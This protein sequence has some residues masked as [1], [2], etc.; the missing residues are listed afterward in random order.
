MHRYLLIFGLTLLLFTPLT[1]VLAQQAT[2]YVPIAK[3]P[4]APA[5]EQI[6]AEK[7]VEY[8]YRLAV[9]VAAMLAVIKIIY[10]GVQWMLTDVVTSKEN[11]KKDI[12]GAI[13]GLIIVL[14]AV[15]ILEVINPKLKEFSI[16]RGAPAIKVTPAGS[17]PAV[18]PSNSAP[19]AP[20]TP[21]PS[22]MDGFN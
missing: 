2:Q 9:V 8:T 13:M 6:T 21:A 20:S 1:L 12:W 3:V 7:F 16:F 11:A 17:S 15:F 18:A 10:G 22:T 5:G 19:T 14:S 4:F